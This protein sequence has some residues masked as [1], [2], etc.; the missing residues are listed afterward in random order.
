M[1]WRNLTGLVMVMG[2]LL[3][4]GQAVAQTC[5]DKA[6]GQDKA[7]SHPC[8]VAEVSVSSV[9]FK[10]NPGATAMPFSGVNLNAWQVKDGDAE[11]KWQV[12]VAEQA[13]DNPKMLTAKDGEGELINLTTG[14][15]ESVDIYSKAKYG[16]VRIELDV[17]VPA[18]SNS[19]ICVMGEYEVQVFDSYGKEK[20]GSGDM[21]AV[22]GAA[23][24]PVNASKAPGEWQ[25]YVILFQAPRFDADGKKTANAQF[26]KIALNGQTL[27]ENLE[28]PGPTPSGVTGKEA[29]LGPI[30]FQGD[31]G[32]VAYRN[33]RI[34]DLA[35]Q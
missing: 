28:M 16:N 21:G 19:G 24:P 13:A 15:G 7:C 8:C 31:H 30:M 33:I 10:C 29:A 25:H 5:C 17:M 12:G 11:S 22:Y 6:A 14:H 23:P 2:V 27:H 34:T 9:C 32:P 18:G 4:A 26:L 1:V 35:V 20:M 3:G